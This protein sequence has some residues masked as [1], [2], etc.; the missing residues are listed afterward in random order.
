MSQSKHT[1]LSYQQE[2]FGS[3]ADICSECSDLDEGILVPV[4]FCPEAQADADRFYDELNKEYLQV[5]IERG[6]K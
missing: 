3:I 1:L 2:K 4:S 6:K 5:L